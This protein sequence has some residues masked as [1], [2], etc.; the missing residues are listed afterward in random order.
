MLLP[1]TPLAPLFQ[2]ERL[3]LS[4]I[5]MLSVIVILYVLGAELVKKFF[6]RGRAGGLIST[7][8]FFVWFSYPASRKRLKNQIF[9]TLVKIL[10]HL[11]Y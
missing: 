11:E 7:T 10:E 4:F 3:P 5:L 6:Y 9:F 1:Y 8:K 2:F